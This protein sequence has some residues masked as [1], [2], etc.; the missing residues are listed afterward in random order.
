M[1]ATKDYADTFGSLVELA[2]RSHDAH[3]L[4]QLRS[5]G[6]RSL[7]DVQRLST[8]TPQGVDP[9]LWRRIVISAGLKPPDIVAPTPSSTSPHLDAYSEN[10]QGVV[11]WLRDRSILG[12]TETV[13]SCGVKR[14]LDLLEKAEEISR[15]SSGAPRQIFQTAIRE[16]DTVSTPQTATTRTDFPT[17]KS[18]TRGSIAAAL[19]AATTPSR[20]AALTEF[21]EAKFANSSKNARDALWRT[22]IKISA[23][24]NLEPLPL[25]SDL[26][27]KIGASL[28]RGG[29]R[30]AGNYFSRA[31]EEHLKLT[32]LPVP[33]SVNQAIRYAIRAVERGAL[34]D[35]PKE[36]FELEAFAVSCTQPVMPAIAE[37]GTGGPRT[38]TPGSARSTQESDYPSSSEFARTFTVVGC[39]WMT[40]EIEIAAAKKCDVEIRHS[41]RTV[42]WRLPSSKADQEG[43]GVVRSHGCACNRIPSPSFSAHNYD[44][45]RICPYH[46]MKAHL[47]AIEKADPM[48]PLFPSQSLQFLTKDESVQLIRGAVTEIFG[49][50]IEL[51]RIERLGGHSLRVSGAQ[52]MARSGIDVV[53]IQLMGRWGSSTVLRYIQEAPLERSHLIAASF[54]RSCTHSNLDTSEEPLVLA[55]TPCGEAEDKPATDNILAITD[56]PTTPPCHLAA[57]CTEAETVLFAPSDDLVQNVRTNVTH[58][59]CGPLIGDSN[60][61][62]LRCGWKFTRSQPGYAILPRGSKVANRCPRCFRNDQKKDS[63]DRSDSSSSSSDSDS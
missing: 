58:R 6:I 45:S 57:T 18:T 10:F 55:R 1:A 19:E 22:W 4:Q 7:S 12:I 11:N 51:E 5:A 8:S 43:R 31:R 46:L 50:S 53:V 41:D 16:A 42:R 2:K 52:A 40:R 23:A 38:C 60:T 54:A 24:W 39:W 44:V 13:K 14:P 20:R 59:S 33:E 48:S 37:T 63:P 28:K 36:A 15:S 49:P 26:V 62:S 21:E 35:R 34:A 27:N 30:S 3:L 17:V 9:P 61:W 29:Y 25:T 47:L 32:G 56:D